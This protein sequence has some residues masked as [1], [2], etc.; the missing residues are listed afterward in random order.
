MSRSQSTP[1]FSVSP[2]FPPLHLASLNSVPSALK[3]PFARFTH[4]PLASGLCKGPHQY[5]SMGFTLP[6]FSYC[7]ALFCIA[8]SSN[9]FSLNGFR[10]LCTK[11]PGWGYA[12]TARSLPPLPAAI[13]AR[14]HSNARNS[15]PFIYLFHVSLDTQGVGL[16][17]NLDRLSLAHSA[18][19]IRALPWYSR[20][21]DHRIR[22]SVHG[23]RF[24]RPFQLSTACPERSRRVN[25]S[26]TIPAL[27][28]GA[29]FTWGFDER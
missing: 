8:Q 18:S 10:T 4:P 19:I 12:S 15:N 6:L 22:I 1:S 5:Y 25:S 14:A 27:H 2:D 20:F 16:R 11:H 17:S 29:D 23:P 3:S 13:T 9:S 28:S 26:S 21:T 24:H 7:Y